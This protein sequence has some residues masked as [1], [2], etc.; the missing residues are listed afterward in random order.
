M[1]A[2]GLPRRTGKEETGVTDGERETREPGEAG[3]RRRRRLAGVVALLG[4]A[5]LA[6]GAAA[7]GYRSVSAGAPSGWTTVFSDSMTGN[8]GLDGNWVYDTG[9]Q[10]HGNGC[11]SQFGTGEVETNTTS[12]TNVRST[13]SGLQITPVWQGYWTS[14]RVETASDS[15]AAPAGGEM[16]VTATIEQPNPGSGMGYWPA[17]WM[18]GAGFRASGAGTGGNMNCSSWPSVGEVDIME[19]V[20][21]RS[22]VAGT[23][24]CGYDPGGPCNETTGKGSGLTGCSGC[25][26]SFNTY[27]VIINR[28]NTSNESITWYRNGSAYF[29]VSESQ[30]GTSTW[31]SAVD[32]GFFILLDVA[33]GGGFPNGVCGCSTPTSATSSGASMTVNNVA[34]Y[35]TNGQQPTPTPT[36]SHSGTATPTPSHSPTPT[37]SHSPTPTPTGGG[38]GG[39]QCTTKAQAD[40]SADC[41]STHQGTATVTSTSDPSPPGVDGN[42]VAQ[43]GNGVWL[44]Y[45]GV[46]FGTGSTQFDIRVASGAAGGVSGAVEV[47]LDNPANSPIS[48]LDVGNTGGWSS[49]ETLPQ[50]MATVTGVHN[51]YIEFVSG[52]AGNPPFVSLHYI[53][54]PAH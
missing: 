24:H 9:T 32:H 21:A 26:T 29:S 37:P 54:F 17:F 35:T 25:Q 15:F 38:G 7:A 50:N 13:S 52:A 12:Q 46:N 43:V 3:N 39:K 23:L 51:V 1:E 48:T 33:M 8:G 18:L 31:Q 5:A 44:E 36:P 16:E 40:I 49:W 14:G 41:F 42:Q 6:V 34:V 30:I 4:A 10:Y 2:G 47:A 27:S 28:T 11:T 19:D 22:Q 20:N 53:T 45:A